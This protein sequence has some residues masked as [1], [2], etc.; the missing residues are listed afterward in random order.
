MF[1]VAIILAELIILGLI[2]FFVIRLFKS[3]KAVVIHTPLPIPKRK[4]KPNN[5][6]GFYS[7]K[8]KPIHST[9]S[10]ELI[11]F[12]LSDEELELHR[13]FNDED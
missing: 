1:W 13:M 8:E 12:G 9:R 2:F 4:E 11:P 10:R 5:S 6:M 7:A 3:K